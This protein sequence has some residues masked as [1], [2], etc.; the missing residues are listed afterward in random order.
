MTHLFGQSIAAKP[1]ILSAFLTLIGNA[2]SATNR[3]VTLLSLFLVRFAFVSFIKGVPVS[4]L[5]IYRRKLRLQFIKHL[6]KS[7][8]KKN[9]ENE[10][11][12][13]NKE[14]REAVWSG[15][16]NTER[17]LT[18]FVKLQPPEVKWIDDLWLIPV[19]I[20]Y[21]VPWA[22]IPLRLRILLK[23]L[24]SNISKIK[25]IQGDP[26]EKRILSERTTKE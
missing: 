23:K 22:P 8:T 20:L 11:V 10:I 17:R 26:A 5:R 3:L 6:K 13:S 19:P 4:N 12:D 2:L 25:M 21:Y 16:I 1:L 24:E 7:S 9:V 15:R 14:D 18:I